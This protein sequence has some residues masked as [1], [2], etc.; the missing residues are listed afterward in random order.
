MA[1]QY[2]TGKHAL[3]VCDRC[4]LQYKLK[5]LKEET[6]QGRRT[7]LYVCPPCWDPEHPQDNLGTFPIWD[8]QALRNARPDTTYTES[9][10]NSI[11]SRIIFWGWNP[12]GFDDPLRLFEGHNSLVAQAQVGT[13]T[14]TTS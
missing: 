11:G 14:V 12:V 5:E 4:G 10:N 7:G 9:G 1:N 6:Y 8:P 13:V 2:A 3:G